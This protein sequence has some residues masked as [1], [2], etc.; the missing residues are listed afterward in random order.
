[1]GDKSLR[2]ILLLQS[3]HD[4]VHFFVEQKHVATYSEVLAGYPGKEV[5]MGRHHFPGFVY[6]DTKFFHKLDAEKHPG[7]D[8]INLAKAFFKFNDLNHVCLVQF[9]PEDGLS[10]EHYNTLD[11]YIACIAGAATVRTASP[12]NDTDEKRITL[13]QGNILRIPPKTLHVLYSPEGCITIP[14]KQTIKGKRDHYYQDKSEK[15]M[16][17]ELDSRIHG[18]HYESGTEMVCELK[19]YYEHLRSGEKNV[20]KNILETKMM[21]EKNPN[22][23]EIISAAMVDIRKI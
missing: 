6:I 5:N 10:G 7:S 13:K 20:F 15:R 21:S 22:L 14:I 12:E 19:H 11:E 16:L 2:E 23:L 18:V 8:M 4:A 9:L 1:M 17:N 3:T